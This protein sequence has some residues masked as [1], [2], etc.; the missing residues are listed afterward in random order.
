M[1]K[2]SKPAKDESFQW[3][4]AGSAFA[5]AG[6]A[7]GM[8]WWWLR[9]GSTSSRKQK[10][11]DPNVLVQVKLK[12]RQELTRN[13][14]TFTYALPSP[15]ELLGIQTG[16]HVHMICK[17]EDGKEVSRSY[18]PTEWET[19]GEFTL[20]IKVYPGGKMTGFMDRMKLGDEITL[21]APT[22]NI[23]YVAPG[24]FTMGQGKRAK[25]VKFSTICMLAGGSGITPMYQ[26][27]MDV[28]ANPSD[29]TKLVV[30]LA[31]S[32][33]DDVLMHD[34]LVALGKKYPEQLKI[35]FTVSRPTSAYQPDSSHLTGRISDKMLA[36]VFPKKDDKTISVVCGPPGFEK[37]AKT[38][39]EGLGYENRVNFYRWT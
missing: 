39:L 38:L 22:G 8:L 27:I 5:M 13:V 34:E 33:P 25:D 26:I 14:R 30:L 12:R 23:T 1:T 29:N 7:G 6:V 31:N 17:D 35:K 19:P 2:L 9:G 4:K 16:R 21:R 10:L 24:H 15:T 20:L 36:D 18:T 11:R 28:T 3:V 37:A 32:T